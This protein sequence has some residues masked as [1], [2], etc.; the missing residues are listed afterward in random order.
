MLLMDF[1]VN[2]FQHSICKNGKLCFLTYGQF[3]YEVTV[4][5]ISAH[6]PKLSFKIHTKSI[7]KPGLKRTAGQRTMSGRNGDFTGQN[8]PLPVM[9]TGHGAYSVINCNVL[10][11]L[12][13]RSIMSYNDYW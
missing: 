7:C 10:N 3:Q 12:L 5:K 11:K 8:V 4:C 2:C 13:L 6:W 9:L 1:W